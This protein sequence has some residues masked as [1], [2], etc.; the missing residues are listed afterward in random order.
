[1]K[2][3]EKC[4]SIAHENGTSRKGLPVISRCNERSKVIR[5]MK[6]VPIRKGVTDEGNSVGHRRGE[7]SAETSAVRPDV[8]DRSESRTEDSIGKEKLSA[9]DHR[10]WVV[11]SWTV[12]VGISSPFKSLGSESVGG[13]GEGTRSEC[14]G[15]H[16]R[17][18]VDF[19]VLSHQLGEENSI[20]GSERLRLL[21][22]S[23]YQRQERVRESSN[24]ERWDRELTEMIP[25]T[26]RSERRG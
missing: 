22:L 21:R 6:F 25:T 7:G 4:I 2:Q 8:T 9:I 14:D 19:L 13:E 15:E 11:S 1:M 23:L 18:T 10:S 26:L 24:S 3:Q 5:S 20:V 12:G 17:S 16:D